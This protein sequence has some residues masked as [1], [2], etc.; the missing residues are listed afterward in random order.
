MWWAAFTCPRADLPELVAPDILT[1]TAM[2]DPGNL[3][4]KF[5]DSPSPLFMKG[6][7]HRWWPLT[8]LQL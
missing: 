6:F 5:C 8:Y 7:R 4:A 2:E 1:G 3:T